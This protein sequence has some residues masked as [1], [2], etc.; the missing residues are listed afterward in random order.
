M[1]LSVIIPVY[2]GAETIAF[3]LES[4][5]HQN[6]NF[7]YEII[8][9]DDCST[10]ETKSIVQNYLSKF[11]CIRYYSNEKNCGNAETFYNATKVA[12][13][14]YLHVLDADDFFTSWNK[15]QKQVDFL[16]SHPNFCAVGHESI[17]L[18][19]KSINLGNLHNITEKVFPYEYDPKKIFGFYMHT[20]T[21]MFKNVFQEGR[22]SILKE[23]FCRGDEIRI[24]LVRAITNEN[25]KCLGFVGSV[26]NYHHKGIWSSLSNIEQHQLS[27]D[28]LKARSK[29]IFSGIEKRGIEHKLSK[30]IKKGPKKNDIKTY[31]LNHSLCIIRNNL[32]RIINDPEN[33]NDISINYNY[34]AQADELLE[35]IGRI[36]LFEK[37]HMIA[38]ADYDDNCYVITISG[39]KSDT[40]SGII[41]EIA[42]QIKN[43]ASEGKKVCICSTEEIQTD[44]T[45]VEKYFNEPQIQYIRAKG[46]TLLDKL[47]FLIDT[48][49]KIKP[50][51]MYPYIT[52]TDVVGA[53]LV[54]KHL[55]AE[56]IMRWVSDHGISLG[57]SNSSITT[58]IVNSNSD[59]YTLNSLNL[60]N[61]V[62]I[63]PLSF[64][65]NY[66]RLHTPL[67]K[68]SNLENNINNRSIKI[69]QKFESHNL[70]D[71]FHYLLLNNK[72]DRYTLSDVRQKSFV[73][74]PIFRENGKNH[75][76]EEHNTKRKYNF[77]RE[78][79][80]FFLPEQ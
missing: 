29:Y 19:D 47:E 20:S 49:I 13:G 71:Y 69:H 64:S 63:I 43:F 26:Y 18:T 67:K 53:A 27:I 79:I 46:D 30:L 70:P 15:L 39:F 28:Y 66:E 31:S 75:L 37:R 8:M 56:I 59:C 42:E 35:A 4:V 48:I 5:L 45:I 9:Y 34:S 12:R 77:L 52:H 3:A 58:Y 54:Q 80:Q 51:R 65:H 24:Q 6:T 61:K 78:C 22:I 11:P 14:K 10:D 32:S 50:F 36:C 23:S 33:R 72:S 60:H 68:Y 73:N 40:R 57:I 17:R 21:M 25:I 1:M 74:I 55:A 7:D 41:Q 44:H 76:L 62:N 2:N 16:E 38:S